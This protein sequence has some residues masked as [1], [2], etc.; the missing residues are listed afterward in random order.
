MLYYYIE[1]K[2]RLNN[3]HTHCISCK[4]S[5]LTYMFSRLFECFSFESRH[6]TL[7]FIHGVSHSSSQRPR[8]QKHILFT[9]ITYRSVSLLFLVHTNKRRVFTDL[10]RCIRLILSVWPKMSEILKTSER[11]GACPTANLLFSFHSPHTHTSIAH[12]SLG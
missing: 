10:Q 8:W 3:A 5:M 6:F 11:T 7:F 1:L 4:S 9:L 2:A 12:I